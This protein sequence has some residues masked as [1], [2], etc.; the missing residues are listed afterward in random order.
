MR[1]SFIH[2]MD[3]ADDGLVGRAVDPA[4]GEFPCNSPVNILK[5]AWLS[6]I[7]LYLELV[8]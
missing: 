7:M 6:K 5:F 1:K 8:S 2:L 4:G 3:V